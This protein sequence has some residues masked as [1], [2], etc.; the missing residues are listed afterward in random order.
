MLPSVIRLSYENSLIK[1]P[2][3]YNF[4]LLLKFLN[5]VEFN[6]PLYSFTLPGLIL[7]IMGLYITLNSVKGSFLDGSI[8]LENTI[9]MILLTL[10]G[11]TVAYIGVLLHLI[12]G[13]IRYKGNKS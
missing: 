12:A 2:L 3:K 6:N 7:G 9:L 8:N 5:N 1:N 10:I 11:I 4:K 13:L